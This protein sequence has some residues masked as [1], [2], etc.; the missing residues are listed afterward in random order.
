MEESD[1]NIAMRELEEPR[2]QQAERGSPLNGVVPPQEYRWKPGQS[3]NP[4]G[5]PKAAGSS[6]REW[7]NIMADWTTNDLQEV[8]DDP[9][10]SSAKATAA[11]MWRDARSVERTKSGI[12]IAGPEAERICDQ[13][14]GKP[15][16]ALELIKTEKD[17]TA[18]GDQTATKENYA[19]TKL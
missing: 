4:S 5:R 11:R 8:L 17:E 13:T 15:K 14:A 7:L 12:P 6:I 19:S 1:K 18:N 3:G 10:A 9:N 16:Q 2:V